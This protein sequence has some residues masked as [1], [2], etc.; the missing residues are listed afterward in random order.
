[1]APNDDTETNQ[2]AAYPSLSQDGEIVRHLIRQDRSRRPFSTYA[3]NFLID[4]E[5]GASWYLPDA[6]RAHLRAIGQIPLA[7]QP[8]GTYS[9]HIL[10]RL[11]VDLSFE[12]SRLE[13]NQYTMLDT[14]ELLELGLAAEGK[15][16]RDRQ[17]IL[18]HKAAI[19]FIVE[20]ATSLKLTPETISNVHALLSENLVGER[21]NE[22]GLRRKP[23]TIGTSVYTPLANGHLIR[24]HLQ[25]LAD[26][27]ESI[28]DPFEQSFFLLVH[29]PYL[30][31]FIDVN[32]RTS[33]IVA[34]L[35]FIKAELCPLSFLGVLPLAYTEGLLG[36]Y[37]YQRIELMR[38]VFV[39]AYERSCEQY[40][41]VLASLGEP[42]LIRLRYRVQLRSLIEEA[43]R[44]CELPSKSTLESWARGVANP[45]DEVAPLVA[46]AESDFLDL[47]PEL[48]YRY[49]VR[50]SDV[51][52]WLAANK[53]RQVCA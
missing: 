5:P 52:A 35:S 8:V 14:K 31:P 40:R 48:A 2:D 18:N 51:E 9:R 24:E 4:Y 1:L 42:D 3:A 19:E 22:G 29:I 11:L 7:E 47:R 43:I 10:E 34:Q 21:T 6:T 45:A 26:K 15:P 37:E 28:P 12:S 41:A 44:K 38:D 27:V 16:P 25:I 49:K 32:K 39:S 36:V 50:P 30:Q 20:N 53:G 23:V 46:A 13:G 17:M 33:R